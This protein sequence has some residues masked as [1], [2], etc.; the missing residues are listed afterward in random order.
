MNL[1][2]NRGEGKLPLLEEAVCL[3]RLFKSEEAFVLA[4]FMTC[5][6]CRLTLRPRP[7]EQL[8]LICVNLFGS[9][10][11]GLGLGRKFQVRVINGSLIQI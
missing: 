4:S 10:L 5:V 7:V 11:S 8:S 9:G 3:P 6:G 1:C 2:Y